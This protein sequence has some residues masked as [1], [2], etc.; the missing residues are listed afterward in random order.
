M[1][2]ALNNTSEMIDPNTFKIQRQM[3]NNQWRHTIKIKDLFDEDTTHEL[4]NQLCQSA[5]TQLR[6]IQQ[7][8]SSRK[9]VLDDDEKEYYF[10]KIDEL[11]D[12]FDCLTDDE[13]DI[14][15]LETEFNGVLSDLYDLGDT[16]IR[17]K[18]NQLQ[19]FLFVD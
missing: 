8:E 2:V 15:D 12:S 5:I 9:D 10:S 18:G 7:I 16:K 13:M 3:I 14:D 4:V 19:K 11:V 1:P 6:K 17:L